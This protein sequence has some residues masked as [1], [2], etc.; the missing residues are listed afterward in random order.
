MVPKSA[1]CMKTSSSSKTDEEEANQKRNVNTAGFVP[2]GS[3]ENSKGQHCW[4]RQNKKKKM[5]LPTKFLN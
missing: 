5:E 1:E 4:S 2:L 3:T